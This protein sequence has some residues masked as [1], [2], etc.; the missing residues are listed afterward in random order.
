LLR[1]RGAAGDWREAAQA[2]CP[3][4]AH[5]LLSNWVGRRDVD[6]VVQALCK[7]LGLFMRPRICTAVYI[8]KIVALI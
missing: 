4:Q 3:G 6:G 2:W 7:Y 8:N 5:F 1:S